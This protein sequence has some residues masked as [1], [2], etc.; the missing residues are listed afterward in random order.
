[1]ELTANAIQTVLP[2][3]NILFT[4]TPVCGAK[5]IQHRV[6]SGL[7]TLRGLTNQCNA[8]FLVTFGANIA[9]PNGETV[10]AISLAIAIDGEPISSSN[11][12]VTPAAVD[13]YFNVS[14]SIYITVPKGCCFTIA[15]ENTSTIPVNI[16]D[17]NI[18]A[19]RVS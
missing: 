12:I 14:R 19:T 13:E 6:G 1:M 5:C 11:M 3:Q 15:V 9:V 16:Q 7:I 4:E 18:I 8:R 17:A 10:G 2:S